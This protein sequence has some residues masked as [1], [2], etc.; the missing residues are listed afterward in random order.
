MHPHPQAGSDLYVAINHTYW[1]YELCTTVPT[2]LA[3]AEPLE[4]S[5]TRQLPAAMA[6]QHFFLTAL[7]EQILP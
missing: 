7:S 1:E 6:N 2:H 5:I 3:P 4:E